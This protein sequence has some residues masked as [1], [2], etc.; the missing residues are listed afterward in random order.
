MRSLSCAA[1]V[2]SPRRNSIILDISFGWGYATIS[3]RTNKI[4]G[5]HENARDTLPLQRRHASAAWRAGFLGQYTG[6][7][8]PPSAVPAGSMKRISSITESIL[9]PHHGPPE[10]VPWHSPGEPRSEVPL[11]RIFLNIRLSSSSEPDRL[12]THYAEVPPRPL[13]KLLH[14]G[15]RWRAYSSTTHIEIHVAERRLQPLRVS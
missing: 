8:I 11:P 14:Y 10:G 2:S 15:Y 12:S 13:V 9:L 7:G 1:P 3:L 5:L 6:Y 4:K